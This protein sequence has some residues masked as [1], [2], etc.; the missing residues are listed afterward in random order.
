MKIYSGVLYISRSDSFADG[1]VLAF[2]PTF[3]DRLRVAMAGQQRTLVCPH[4]GSLPP[5]PQPSSDLHEG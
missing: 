3:S 5:G 4:P 1:F 2:K